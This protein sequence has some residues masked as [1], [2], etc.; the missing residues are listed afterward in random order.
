MKRYFQILWPKS[1]LILGF[2]KSK[3]ESQRLFFIHIFI[4]LYPWTGFFMNMI[5]S[6]KNRIDGIKG[7][8]HFLK[9]A[10]RIMYFEIQ[11]E[12]NWAQH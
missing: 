1:E 10:A 4:T 3:V 11:F 6:L 12:C 2:R 9:R 7:F 5:Y 8:V